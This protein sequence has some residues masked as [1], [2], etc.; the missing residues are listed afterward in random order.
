MINSKLQYGFAALA[1]VCCIAVSMLLLTAG[2]GHSSPWVF[3][4]LGPL[5][6]GPGS[7]IYSVP[8]EWFWAIKNH[9]LLH[10]NI[11]RF[12]WS[13]KISFPLHTIVVSKFCGVQLAQFRISTVSSQRLSMAWFVVNMNNQKKDT[14]ML[15][16]DKWLETP[17][18][19]ALWTSCH[20]IKYR[21]TRIVA[22]LFMVQTVRPWLSQITLN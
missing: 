10:P 16:D 18:L 1:E 11:H 20:P 5:S 3:K 22:T 13:Y 19:S 6:W 8:W 7:S 4:F 15:V 14:D 12:A 17:T 2:V 21:M 9:Y